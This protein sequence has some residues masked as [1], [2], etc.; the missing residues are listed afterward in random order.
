PCRRPPARNCRQCPG[1][2]LTR[3]TRTTPSAHRIALS[4]KDFMPH[5]TPVPDQIRQATRT[6]AD[7]A[8]EDQ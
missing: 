7:P 2:A 5:H 4:A 6:L 3:P 8:P 1:P